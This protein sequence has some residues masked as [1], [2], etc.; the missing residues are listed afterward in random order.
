MQINV[1][2]KIYVMNHIISEI[3]Q[4]NQN[5]LGELVR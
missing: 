3:K 2:M 1:L 5:S 4:G